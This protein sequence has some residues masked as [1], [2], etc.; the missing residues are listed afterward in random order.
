MRVVGM[1]EE[2]LARIVSGAVS[3]SSGEQLL[4]ELELLRRSLEHRMRRLDR[5]REPV[6]YLDAVEHAGVVAEQVEDRAQPAQQALAR[7]GDG[8]VDTDIVSGSGEEIGDAVAHQA[9]ADD[10]DLARKHELSA[11]VRRRVCPVRNHDALAV[12]CAPKFSNHPAMRSEVA[13]SRPV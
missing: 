1:A 8:L 9:G 2:L 12:R 6:M 11:R 10:R 5:R 7:L 13:C 3:F 4:L